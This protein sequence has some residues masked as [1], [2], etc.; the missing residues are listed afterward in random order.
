MAAVVQR[1]YGPRPHE[2]KQLEFWDKSL[3]R[4][5]TNDTD[6]V[7]TLPPPPMASI[8]VPLASHTEEFYIVNT[9]NNADE[10]VVVAARYNVRVQRE[11]LVPRTEVVIKEGQTGYFR[12][13][14]D[15]DVWLGGVLFG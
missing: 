9:G 11:N 3:Q 1:R 7:I 13:F 14:S 15:D 12:Y 10:N 5:S 2:T 8:E 4:I 6:Y